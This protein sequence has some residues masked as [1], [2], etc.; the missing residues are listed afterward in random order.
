MF[1]L[2]VRNWWA[3][4][5]RGAL[6]V[7]FGVL[8]LLMPGITLEVLILL[9]GAY[10][11]VDGIFAIVAGVRAARQGERWGAPILEGAADIIAG[12]IALFVPVAVALAFIYLVA[13]WA[14]VTGA[15]EIA[16]AIRLR[17]E[18][19]GEWLMILGG[20]LS[21]LFGLAVAVFP[22]IGLLGLLWAIGVYAIVFGIVL[23]A[24]AFRLHRLRSEA[25]P[26][27]T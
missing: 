21:I 3:L 12:A 4:A 13:V 11:A 15:L 9:F 20:V 16:T 8:T 25:M 22:G 10:A 26:A 5:L 2:L 1:G 17:R 27:R 6:A 24:L 14:L 7:I 23:M 19:E 18:I